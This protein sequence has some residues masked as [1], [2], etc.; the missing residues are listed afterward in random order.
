MTGP[1]KSLLSEHSTPRIQIERGV[2]FLDNSFE[3]AEIA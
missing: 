3:E 1:P 2:C